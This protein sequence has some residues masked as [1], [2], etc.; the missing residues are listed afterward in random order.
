MLGVILIAI[1]GA[2][3][4]STAS[5]AATYSNMKRQQK[6]DWEKAKEARKENYTQFAKKYDCYY[7][8]SEDPHGM[9]FPDTRRHYDGTQK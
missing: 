3:I 5:D 8:A 6:E 9:F 2:S 4:L 1:V 7:R